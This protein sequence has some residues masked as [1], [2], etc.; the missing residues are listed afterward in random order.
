MLA[1]NTANNTYTPTAACKQETTA[2]TLQA[3]WVYYP[4]TT[5]VGDSNSVC[6]KQRCI[7][8]RMALLIMRH[9]RPPYMNHKQCWLRCSQQSNITA[10]GNFAAGCCATKD[11]TELSRTR[12][13]Y[14]TNECMFVGHHTRHA[15]QITQ[16]CCVVHAGQHSAHRHT[17]HMQQSCAIACVALL[18]RTPA[19]STGA[20]AEIR[21]HAF[22][23]CINLKQARWRKATHH[24]LA[25]QASTCIS[26]NMPCHPTE[27]YKAPGI[28]CRL[29]SS[30][31]WSCTI[32]QTGQGA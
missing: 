3:D 20:K 5:I 32:A 22:K 15:T 1:A 4:P 24:A 16:R 30:R 28:F 6:S 21:S 19:M 26:T 9:N 11:H 23:S 29:S 25:A 31:T 17:C 12:N 10:S 18:V 7:R 8:L 2:K 14:S 27:P 13:P